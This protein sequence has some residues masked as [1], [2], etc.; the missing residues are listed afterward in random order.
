MS[1]NIQQE[2]SQIAKERRAI[3]KLKKEQEKK[4]L[5]GK[6]IYDYSTGKKMSKFV[7]NKKQDDII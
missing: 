4:E 1:V 6:W 3:E 2:K 5:N 7:P